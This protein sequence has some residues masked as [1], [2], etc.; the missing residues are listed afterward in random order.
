VGHNGQVDPVNE[1]S[2][3]EWNNDMTAIEQIFGNRA[4]TD[5]IRVPASEEQMSYGTPVTASASAT[6]PR[7]VT[8]ARWK[9][10]ASSL[11]TSRQASARVAVCGIPSTARGRGAE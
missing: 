5:M 9:N 10:T 6:A 3:P 1:S 4:R 2:A 7:T 11:P 8:Y